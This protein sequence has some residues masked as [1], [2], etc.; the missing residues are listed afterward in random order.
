MSD[1]YKVLSKKY[2]PKNHSLLIHSI[3]TLNRLYTV[4]LRCFYNH[5]HLSDIKML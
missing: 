4:E 5:E 2:V 3:K 1:V